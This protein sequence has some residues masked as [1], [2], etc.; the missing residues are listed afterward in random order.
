[1]ARPLRI[2]YAGAWYHVINRGAGRRAIFPGDKLR[3]AFLELLGQAHERYGVEI[4]AWCLMGNHYHVV[5]RTQQANLDRAMRHVDGVYTQRHN[6]MRGTDGPLFRGRY[7]SIVVDGDAYLAEL[8]RYVH[9]NP[10]E[11]HLVERAEHWPWSSYRSYLGQRACP[12]WLYLD[13]LLSLFGQRDAR[14]AYRR[15]VNRGVD[16]ELAAFYARG[17]LRPV[18]GSEAFCDSLAKKVDGIDPMEVPDVGRIA[19]RPDIQTIVAAT[20][21]VCDVNSAEVV[22]SVRGRENLPRAIAMSL[23]QSPGGHSLKAIARSFGL[24]SYT[25]VSTAIRRLRER[26]STPEVRALIAELETRLFRDD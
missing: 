1:M 11:A 2:R 19:R 12:P 16:P 3:Y 24:K 14:R 6:R 26:R 18:L 21:E 17:P 15:F 25:G 13:D 23:C 4:H 7:T 8:S 9:R 10:V 20:A 22:Q 5:C